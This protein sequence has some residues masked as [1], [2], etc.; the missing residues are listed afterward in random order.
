MKV[1]CKRK[2]IC[3]LHPSPDLSSSETADK[4]AEVGFIS[5]HATIA[6]NKFKNCYMKTKIHT[7]SCSLVP[8]LLL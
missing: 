7:S 5:N 6:I 2:S 1:D 4:E 3:C 8:L